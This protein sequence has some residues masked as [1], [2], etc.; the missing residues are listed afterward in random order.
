MW[1]QAFLNHKGNETTS[2]TEN[3]Y[4]SLCSETPGKTSAFSALRRKISK[5]VY[6]V[7]AFLYFE[8][9]PFCQMYY[10]QHKNKAMLT[11]EGKKKKK[12]HLN[13]FLKDT[14]KDQKNIL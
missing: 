14:G 6:T 8:S 3:V 10:R 1:Q 9:F 4:T 12:K 5:K 11:K 2:F 13:V 7:K